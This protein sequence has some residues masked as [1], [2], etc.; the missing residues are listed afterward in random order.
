MTDRMYDCVAVGSGHAGC[1]AAL[2]AVDSGCKRVL[3]VDKCPKE[4]AGGN[5]YF[6]A[7]AHR[8]VHAGLRDLLPIVQNVSPET[9]SSIDM[10]AY[11]VDEFTADI[12]RLGDGQP[13][14]GV[15]AAVVEGSREAVGWLAERV[16]VPFVFSFNR[17]A[18]LVN[19]RQRFWGGMVLGVEG[20]GKGLIAAHHAAL[21]QAGV[22]VWF[23]TPAVELSVADG[24]VN[25]IAIVHDGE[26]VILS[27]S[28][29]ILACGGFESSSELRSKHLGA[30][31][32]GAKV[33][34][35]PYNT[36]DGLA[37]AQSV[38]A[39]M[40]GDFNSCH[41]TCWDANAPA[42]RGDRVL[43][44]QFTKSGYPLGIM[45]NALGHRFIDEGIDFRNYTYAKFGRE[46]L[47]QPGGF[48][49]QLFDSQVIPWLRSEE[50][51]DDVVE[52]ICAQTLD[53]LADKLSQIGLQD[54]AAF[55]DTVSRYND[56]VRVFHSE[57]SSKV[58]DPA[59]KDGL[60]TQSSQLHLEPAKSN[61]ALPLDKPPF[62]VVKVS[63][64][65]TFTFGGLAIDSE[66][67]S[68][69][70]DAT[71]TPIKGLFCAGELVGGLFYG[72][73]PG[74]SG[75]TAGAVFGRKAGESAAKVAATSPLLDN[76]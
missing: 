3:I 29:V 55:L 32:E 33:R 51:A 20:G 75:L 13:H 15:V 43:S 30:H 34:G 4:W 65:I 60:S 26:R 17:Q 47:A 62:L 39:K 2:S 36:G 71:G 40:A 10:D 1:C 64:G 23:E 58:W 21:E 41:S 67:A 38:G 35:T 9:A 54:R 52:K 63:C 27:T 74:G 68:V 6:T 57:S 24:S 50:Y 59:V 73:Y 5:G 14:P 61:W 19:G 70:S 28:A 7:G 18:Y 76:R 49:F 44:N 37:L 45:V 25:G 22:E 48:A 46:I 69:L 42:D 66:T 53:E 31:W 12:M 11:S 56:A 16:K 8:T 72:N